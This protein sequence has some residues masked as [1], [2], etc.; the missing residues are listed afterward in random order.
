MGTSPNGQRPHRLLALVGSF[1]APHPLMN[2]FTSPPCVPAPAQPPGPHTKADA[3]TDTEKR[4]I[5]DTHLNGLLAQA[6][7]GN[8]TAFEAFYDATMAHAQ[9]LARRMLP[10]SDVE[11]ILAD[12]FFQAWREAT[13]FDPLRGGPVTWLLTIVRSRALDWLR[14]RR[15]S[16]EVDVGDEMPDIAANAPGPDTLL[17]HAQSDSRLQ[18][19]LVSLSANERWV[20]GLAYYREM[21]HSAIAECTGLPLGTVKSL[22]LRAQHKLREQ[23][24]C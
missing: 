9:A 15:A 14:H 3:D 7:Q 20:L 23:L 19:A 2:P 16:P 24:V 10:P 17:A 4:R 6:A 18:A 12:A 22:I 13:R 11:D 21:A 5:R 1:D 8:A